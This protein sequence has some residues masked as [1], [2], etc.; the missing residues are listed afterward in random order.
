MAQINQVTIV[1]KNLRRREM[2]LF[3]GDFKVINDLGS[4]GGGTPL[5]LVFCEKRKGRCANFS[6]AGRGVSQ[7]ASS[8]DV[9]SDVF[10]KRLLLNPLTVHYE[11]YDNGLT[12][13]KRNNLCDKAM[14]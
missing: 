1:G 8:A 13:V 14:D 4:K 6:R 12:G 2:I 9:R 3:T 7:T 5:T 11:R 10:H